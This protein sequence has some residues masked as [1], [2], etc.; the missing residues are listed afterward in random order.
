MLSDDVKQGAITV[1]EAANA[2]LRKNFFL[3]WALIRV[4]VLLI[5]EDFLYFTDTLRTLQFLSLL[6]Y[7]SAEELVCLVVGKKA[8]GFGVIIWF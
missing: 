3:Q 4:G 8:F 6:E 1:I 5:S 7:I 2:L